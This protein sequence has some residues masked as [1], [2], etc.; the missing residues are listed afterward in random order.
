VPSRPCRV[1]FTDSEGVEHA[2]ELAAASLYEAAVMALAE[3]RR[4]G[5]AD[6]SFGPGTRLTVKVKAPET[7]HVVSVGKLHSWL[8][9]GGKSPNEQVAKKRL[10]EMLS[11]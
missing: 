9:G 8:D 6:A 5:F 1:S 3:F 7:E 2:V 11:K 10:K 4:C